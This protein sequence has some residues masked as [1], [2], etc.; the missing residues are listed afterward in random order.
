MT[1]F[2]KSR[3]SKWKPP[4]KVFAKRI[5]GKGR[6]VF[7]LEDIKK[8]EIIED[9]PAIVFYEAEWTLI[10]LTSVAAYPFF[11]GRD[12]TMLVLGYGSL[13]NTTHDPN[14]RYVAMGDFMRYT[15]RKNI[16]AGEEITIDYAW[17]KDEYDRFKIPKKDR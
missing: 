4:T 7:A 11:D 17:S 10:E 15:A 2:V 12:G 1:K 6:G 14:A 3:I 5:K 16:K 13:Y 9:A 8:G